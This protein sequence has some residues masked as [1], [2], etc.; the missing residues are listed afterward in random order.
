MR[1]SFCPSFRITGAAP[2]RR[3]SRKG[4][5]LVLTAI[6][7]VVLMAMVAFAVD[8]GYMYT[9]QSELQRS[10]DAAALAGAG[11]LCDGEAQAQGEA[12][13]YLV[14]N[15]V[16][17]S[18]TAVD[19]SQLEAAKLRFISDYGEHLDLRSGNWNPVTRQM[20]PASSNPSTLSV[21]MTYPHRPLFFA[22]VLGH[23]DF[24]VHA[25]S[26]AMYQ[27]RDIVVVL[28]FSASMNDDS[29]FAAYDT[30]GKAA[31]DANLLQCYQDLGSPVY[32]TMEFEPD[33]ITVKGDSPSN[34]TEPQIYVEYRYTSVYVT[35][36]KNLEN[37]VVRFSNG[38]K[39]TFSGLS[40]KTGTFEGTGYNSGRA[41]ER[42]W[43]KSG[44]NLSG[45]GYN[46]G[47]PFDFDSSTIN[48]TIKRALGL[49]NVPYPYPSGSWDAYINNC[50]SSSGL[51]RNAGYRYQFGYK[52]L[53]NYWLDQE[54]QYNQTPDLWKTSA[55]PVTALKA[56]TDV[57]MDYIREVP[58]GDRVGLAIYDAADGNAILESPLTEDFDAVVDIVRHRQAGHYHEYTNIGAGME[59]A[60]RHLDQYGRTN[61]FKMIVLMT[62]G[63]A[64]WINGYYSEGAANQYVLNEA[65][66]SAAKSRR[67]PVVCISLGAGADLNIMQ[68]VANITESKHYNVPGGR[69]ISQVEEDL[70]QV[71]RDIADHR[72]LKLVK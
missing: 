67:Y 72:P 1:A 8:V 11:M 39:Q 32:G 71:F 3:E 12:V 38:S 65:N 28:D 60:R 4:N 40:T 7:M 49:S 63:Q 34:S 10:V 55:Q 6:M 66:L 64:N 25:E 27:P 22:R 47:E 19:E 41:I 44:N 24:S 48:T 5:I 29:T 36:T 61:A 57:F 68:Q 33:Y 70:K 62:D 69:P 37:V 50:K 18:L 31:V 15:P 26:I 45:E 59:A 43:V 52:N 53:I 17:N 9:M 46:Y 16:G 13:E 56:A 30:L 58:T 42:V 2:P 23:D 20:E 21:S 35:S 14:R 54:P 51:N